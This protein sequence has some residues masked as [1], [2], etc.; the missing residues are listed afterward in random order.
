[1]KTQGL[2]GQGI[3]AQVANVFQ[4]QGYVFFLSCIYICYICEGGT[5]K[6]LNYFS[7]FDMRTGSLNDEHV[8]TVILLMKI[9]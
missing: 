9:L 5:K 7:F 4:I 1:M 6:N 3:Q 8:F 2:S